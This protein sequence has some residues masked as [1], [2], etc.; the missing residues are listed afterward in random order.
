MA[1]A[2]SIKRT[3]FRSFLGQLLKHLKISRQSHRLS[4]PMGAQA[5]TVWSGAGNSPLSAG[6][7]QPGTSQ[8]SGQTSQGCWERGWDFLVFNLGYKG[9]E[10]GSWIN[11]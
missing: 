7:G 5:P 10:D 3:F 8:H 11:A 9:R 1:G 6:T 2:P 4:S